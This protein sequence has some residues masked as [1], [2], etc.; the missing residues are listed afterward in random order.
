MK[1]AW[2]ILVEEVV[3]AVDFDRELARGGFQRLPLKGANHAAF[4]AEQQLIGIDPAVDPLL[5][6]IWAQFGENEHC[7]LIRAHSASLSLPHRTY[8]QA[9]CPMR[10]EAWVRLGSSDAL[11][12]VPLTRLM[13][14]GSGLRPA[15]TSNSL[16]LSFNNCRRTCSPRNAPHVSQRH[17][18]SILSHPQTFHFLERT[19]K[20]DPFY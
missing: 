3:K 1:H 10:S 12:K 15:M 11:R 5:Q 16:R 7:L 18:L 6:L 9:D 8:S 4:L 14:V 17:W 20:N 13:A 19:A 2:D